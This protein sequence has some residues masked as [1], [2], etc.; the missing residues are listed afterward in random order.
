MTARTGN[1][2]GRP[3]GAGKLYGKQTEADAND[4]AAL[5]NAPA[6]RVSR[7]A[8]AKAE[9]ERVKPRPESGYSGAL[10]GPT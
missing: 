4:T 5:R 3:R 1:P 10:R 8:L 9:W 2:V 7:Y 6:P